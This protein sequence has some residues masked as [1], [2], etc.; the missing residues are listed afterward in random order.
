MLRLTILNLA[1]TLTLALSL[2]QVK[3][4]MV[5]YGLTDK[6]DGSR[7]TVVAGDLEADRLGLDERAYFELAA[8]L[9]YNTKINKV[10]LFNKYFHNSKHHSIKI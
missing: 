3:R 10:Q 6:Y 2:S 1:L 9:R 5:S 8:R 7:V 4:T